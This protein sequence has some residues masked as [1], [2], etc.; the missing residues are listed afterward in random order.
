MQEGLLPQRDMPA[1]SQDSRAQQQHPQP[2]RTPHEL[3]GTVVHHSPL[4]GRHQQATAEAETGAPGCLTQPPVAL[5]ACNGAWGQT[6]HSDFVGSPLHSKVTGHGIWEGITTG[7]RNGEQSHSS[8]F[9]GGVGQKAT[10]E[11]GQDQRALEEPQGRE[12][13]HPKP[14][15]IVTRWIHTRLSQGHLPSQ[16]FRKNQLP[17]W[18]H[19]AHRAPARSF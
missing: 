10:G 3:H 5:G 11:S 9:E 16:I 19:T 13:P 12:E 4:P 14:R 17:Y 8:N 2:H 15:H 1:K 6:V 7:M 18:P